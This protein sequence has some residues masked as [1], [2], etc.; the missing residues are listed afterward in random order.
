MGERS[1]KCLI[2]QPLE[3]GDNPQGKSNP[4]TLSQT[5]PLGTWELS[6]LVYKMSG[7]RGSEPQ[8]V[9]QNT[10]EH[11]ETWVEF[12]RVEPSNLHL[13]KASLEMMILS[14]SQETQP[15]NY[16]INKA[17]SPITDRE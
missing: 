1:A 6:Y 10:G 13:Q 5:S 4:D 16:R 9:H 15:V 12:S 7:C 3:Q 11:S 17:A 8:Q 14:G 2:L